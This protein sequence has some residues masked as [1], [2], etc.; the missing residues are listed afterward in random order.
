MGET[1]RKLIINEDLREIDFG[2]W[3]GL[4][5]KNI[6]ERRQSEWNTWKND[7]Y[8]SNPYNGESLHNAEVRIIDFYSSLLQE[9]IGQTVLLVSHGGIL[10]IF[11]SYLF[12]IPLSVIW[13]FKLNPASF[14]ELIIY[15]NGPELTILNYSPNTPFKDMY[16]RNIRENIS[17]RY[18]TSFPRPS[19]M[20]R[21]ELFL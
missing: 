15:P 2:T 5:W 11:L 21:H 20:V 7:P 12:Q 6:I 9:Y 1:S 19:A 13:T 14:S 17:Q 4:P 10:N 18:E 16:I 8:F 3:E